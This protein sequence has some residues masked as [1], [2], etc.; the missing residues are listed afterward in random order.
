MREKIV[1]ENSVI[2][3]YSLMEHEYVKTLIATHEYVKSCLFVI[4][5]LARL[6][7]LM[8]YLYA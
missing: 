5:F 3:Y 8:I 7:R 1:Y 6:G 2:I 4:F